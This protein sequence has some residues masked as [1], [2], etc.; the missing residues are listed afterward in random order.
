MMK[1][2]ER[3]S[4]PQND[5]YRMTNRRRENWNDGILERISSTTCPA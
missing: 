1:K 2:E 4:E 3:K 5:E